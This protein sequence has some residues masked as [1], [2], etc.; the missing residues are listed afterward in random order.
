MHF[1][2]TRQAV[3]HRRN[4]GNK[5]KV[6]RQKWENI[7]A[8]EV[9]GAAGGFAARCAESLGSREKIE[10]CHADPAEREKHPCISFKNK[11][12]DPSLP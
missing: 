12:G 3:R 5:A 1:E 8:V 6:K 2:R 11:C 9:R 4:V 7:T 10:Y